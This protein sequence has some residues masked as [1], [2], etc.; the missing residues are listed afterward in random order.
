MQQPAWWKDTPAWKKHVA[1]SRAI[2]TLGELSM[3]AGC[4]EVGVMGQFNAPLCKLII[5]I[6]HHSG[7]GAGWLGAQAEERFKPLKKKTLG[8][9][10]RC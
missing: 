7:N 9:S 2:A 3:G 1:P 4:W 5:S 10:R 8:Q 6:D